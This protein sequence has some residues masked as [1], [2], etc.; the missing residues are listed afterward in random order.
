M[1][2]KTSKLFRRLLLLSNVLVIILLLLSAFSW[3]F[4][5]DIW[6]FIAMMGMVFPIL[7]VVAAVYTLLG[8]ILKKRIGLISFVALLLCIPAILKSY[9]MRTGEIQT[10]KPTEYLRVLSWNVGLMNFS[11]R[12]TLEAIEKNLILLKSIKESDA[13]LLCFQE[14]LTSE[15]PNGHYNFM[16]SITR[17]MNYPHRY[18]NV[19][20]KLANDFFSVGT[21]IMSRYPIKDSLKVA[22]DEPFPGS[23]S[24]VTVDVNGKLIDVFSTRLQSLNFNKNEY[25]IFDRLKKADLKAMDGSKGLIKK[26]KYAYQN[27]KKQ[28]STVYDLMQSSSHPVLFAGDLNDLPNS[29]AY[30]RIKGDKK[31]LWLNKGWG[32]GRTFSKISPTLRIDYIFADKQFEAQGVKR[33]LTK[34][35]DHYGLLGDFIIK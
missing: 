1:A 26:I 6:W 33:L 19:D 23:V 12:D 25:V 10:K 28:I 3:L 7:F 18:Y 17:T 4:R 2:L 32:F 22:F 13:D 34:G 35:S 27:R 8:L 9:G 21:L 5:P 14:F 30:K 11:A 24:Q 31:D 20:R 16:D 15:I 29:Y